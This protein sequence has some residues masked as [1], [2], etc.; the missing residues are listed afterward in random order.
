MNTILC[1]HFSTYYGNYIMYLFNYLWDVGCA[2]TNQMLSH[3]FLAANGLRRHKKSLNI[4]SFEKYR[5]VLV[6]GK[7]KLTNSIV[8]NECFDEVLEKPVFDFKKR[9]FRSKV[10]EVRVNLF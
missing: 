1:P 6:T 2:T 10:G 4:Q 8:R 3:T 5:L 7:C 9:V